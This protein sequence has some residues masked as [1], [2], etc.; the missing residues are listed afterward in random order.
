VHEVDD[1]QRSGVLMPQHEELDVH[2]GRPTKR[3]QEKPEHLLEDQIQLV[4]FPAC[5]VSFD[6]RRTESGR[7]QRCCPRWIQSA[8]SIVA[9]GNWRARPRASASTS[10]TSFGMDQTPS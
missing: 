6:Q 3:Q 9:A 2:G 8:G 1:D 5:T 4:S 10:S 7:I